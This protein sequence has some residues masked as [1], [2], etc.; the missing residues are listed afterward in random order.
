MYLP[1]IDRDN[2]HELITK[3][4]DVVDHID[5]V[6]QRMVF[7]KIEAITSD[8]QSQCQVLVRAT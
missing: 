8:F 2:I 4:D 6:A 7:Y 1:P 5:A 3:I